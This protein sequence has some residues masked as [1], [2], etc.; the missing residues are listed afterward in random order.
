VVIVDTN[1]WVEA[2]DRARPNSARCIEVLRLYRT[3]LVVPAVV[4]PEAAWFIEDR[5][6]PA[7]EAIFLRTVT[8]PAV[9]IV[10]LIAADWVRVIELVET[11]AD[12]GLGTVDASIIAIAERLGVTTIATMNHRDF[13]VV[14]P[15]HTD[16]FGLVP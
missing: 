5:L 2:A 10:D 4:I 13:S 16:G 9:E 1:I 6:G 12:L 11:Y 8:S 7:A 3:E 15:T 14:R